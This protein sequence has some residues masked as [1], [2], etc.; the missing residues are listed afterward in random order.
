[1]MRPV[2]YWKKHQKKDMEAVLQEFHE[3]GWRIED[4]PTY[5]QVKCPCAGKHKRSVHLT[6]SNPNY[7][8]DTRRWLYRQPCYQR[9]GRKR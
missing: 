6:P 7:A 2:G 3:A 8:K 4:P 5:Y 9:G 1:M